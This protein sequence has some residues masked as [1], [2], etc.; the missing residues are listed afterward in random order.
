VEYLP[1]VVVVVFQSGIGRIRN[2]FIH[3]RPVYRLLFWHMHEHEPKALDRIQIV[4]KYIVN[5]IAELVREG[6]TGNLIYYVS[7]YDFG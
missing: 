5:R 1:V 3:Q 2:V 6:V 4:Y 7:A